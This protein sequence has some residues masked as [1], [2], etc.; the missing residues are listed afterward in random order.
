MHSKSGLVVEDGH[1]GEFAETYVT[2]EFE[3]KNNVTIVKLTHE[4]LP[5]QKSRALDEAG[6][7]GCF[8]GLAGIL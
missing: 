3:E 6:W 8:D 4:F 1:E 7:K 2:V 5:S